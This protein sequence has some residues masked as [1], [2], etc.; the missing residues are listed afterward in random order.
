MSSDVSAPKEDVKKEGASNG[1]EKCTS[2]IY[3]LMVAWS[4]QVQKCDCL[5][6]FFPAESRKMVMFFV[7]VKPK[8]YS[9]REVKEQIENTIGIVA[10]LFTLINDI[11]LV[12][13][14]YSESHSHSSNRTVDSYKVRTQ[15]GPLVIKL[16]NYGDNICKTLK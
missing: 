14:C 16:L 9:L 8:N 3:V 6:L 12:P 5:I 4:N 10:K 2:R 13:V 1:I 15:K 11:A 7:E